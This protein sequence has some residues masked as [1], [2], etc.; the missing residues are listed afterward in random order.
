MATLERERGRNEYTAGKAQTQRQREVPSVTPVI[1]HEWHTEGD[2]DTQ[3]T[4]FLFE[5]HLPDITKSFL[6]SL[7]NLRLSTYKGHQGPARSSEP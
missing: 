6:K 1:P 5:L 4:I 3:T 2:H 7:Y